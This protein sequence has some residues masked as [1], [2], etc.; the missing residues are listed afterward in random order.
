MAIRERKRPSKAGQRVS[1]VQAFSVREFFARFPNDDACLEHLM[2]QRYGLKSFCPDCGVETTF[3]RLANRKAFSGAACGHHV[4][5]Q[6][7]TI[8]QDSRTPLQTW[9]YAIY[10]FIATRHGVSAKELQRSLGVTYKTAWRI[11]HQVRDLMAK[12]DGFQM[13]KGHVEADEAYVG[14]RRSGGK[15]G[16]GAEGKTIVMAM[17][18]RGGRLQTE[19][20]PNVQKPTLRAVVNANVETGAIVST[21]ELMSYGLLTGDGYVHGTV[22]HGQ[23]EWAVYDYKNDVWHSTN[24]AESFWNLF[25]ASVR[26]THIQISGKHMARY[27]KEFT[28]WQNHRERVNLMFDVVVGAL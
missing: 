4:Y 23:E 24:G 10:L 2:D 9:Y 7:G 19:I 18:E 1:N 13:L 14:G 8:F 21:D 16:R 15:R 25:K 12:T 3:H 26:S 22:K 20:V 27:L 11:G 28:F 5:P 17:K 6:A